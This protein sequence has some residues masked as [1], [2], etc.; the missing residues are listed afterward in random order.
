M[1]TR[2]G[3]VERTLAALLFFGALS[4]GAVAFLAGRGWE[5][6]FGARRPPLELTTV[7]TEAYGVKRGS[8]VMIA[9]VEAGSVRDVSVFADEQ[10]KV[11]VETALVV[12]AR[13]RALLRR[14]TI[15]R[16]K[17]PPLLGETTIDLLP[18]ARGDRLAGGDRITAVAPE[19]L[20]EEIA[21][22]V[23]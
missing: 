7:T 22:G 17:K 16:V 20:E 23:R 18:G 2:V 15:A 10:G 6:L 11:R 5:D 19:R 13:Y 12:D 1:H 3:K 14:G 9:G 8:P 21:A 4:G